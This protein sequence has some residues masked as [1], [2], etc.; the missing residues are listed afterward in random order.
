MNTGNKTQDARS[1]KELLGVDGKLAL[2]ISQFAADPTCEFTFII[3]DGLRTEKEQAELVMKGAS[4]TLKSKHLEGK[5]IDIC[6]LLAGKARWEFELY[7]RF[8]K[9][10]LNYASIHHDLSLT[11]GGNWKQKDGPHFEIKEEKQSV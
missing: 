8:A 1:F 3:T 5:A 7:R 9:S 2:V 4:W 6:I 11:W 10:F